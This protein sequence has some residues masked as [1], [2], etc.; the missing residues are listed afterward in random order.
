MEQKIKIKVITKEHTTKD[1]KRKFKT[2]FTPCK[3]IV[4]GE[5]EKGKQ[6]KMLSVKFKEGL[7][8]KYKVEYLFGL[9]YVPY[10]YEIKEEDGKKK[11]PFIYILKI[12]SEEVASSP[13]DVDFED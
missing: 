8:P 12:D 5:E 1:G 4:K 11:Y 7:T 10:T 2:Y 9:G 3:I 6:A 13:S